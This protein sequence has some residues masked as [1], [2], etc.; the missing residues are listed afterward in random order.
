MPRFRIKT[1]NHQSMPLHDRERALA[2]W[3]DVLGLEVIPAQEGG[4]DSRMIWMKAA[5]GTMVHLM[6][7]GVDGTPNIHTAFEVE[8]FDEA[9]QAA[10]DAGLEIIKGPLERDDG[11]RAFYIY[12][13]E[14][15]RLE[16]TTRSGLKPS[17]RTVDSDGFTQ[18]G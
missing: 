8:N 1:I 15:N 7:R 3:R 9:L 12:D 13:P 14:G 11:Q 4:P 17:P 18:P 6:P 5:D 2:F 10:K 16:F